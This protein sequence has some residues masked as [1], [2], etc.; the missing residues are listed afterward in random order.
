MQQKKENNLF[1]QLDFVSIVKDVCREWWVILLL[2]IAVSLLTNVFVNYTY[3]PQY[4]ASTTFVVTAKG[5]NANIYQ[6]LTSAKELAV[7]FSNVLESNVMKKKIAQ[8]LGMEN[9]NA[10]S[11]VEIL[12]ETNLIELKVTANSSLDAYRVMK[13]IMENYPEVSDYVISNVVLEV[14]KKPTIPTSPSNPLNA[15]GAMKKAFVISAAV[16]VVGFA[17]LSYLKDTV[18]NK[19]EV[20]EKVDAPLLGTVSHE[21]KAKSFAE[22]KKA[23]SLSM[24]IDNPMLSFRFVE[25]NKMMA[26]R[27]RSQLDKHGHKVLMLTSVIENEGKSTV[28]ANIALSLVQENKKVLLI[29]CDFRKPAQYKIFEAK[30]EDVVDFPKF[31][32]ENIKDTSLI[33]QYGDTSLYTIFNKKGSTNMERIYE[34]GALHKLVEIAREKMDYIILDTSPMALVSDTEELAQLADACILVIRQDMVLAKDINDAIDAL[35]K[36]NGNMLGCIFN[37]EVMGVVESVGHYG[38]GYGRYGYG[39]GKY[40]YGKRYG[41]GYGKTK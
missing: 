23:K 36:A 6:N 9:L 24:L 1:E 12:P 37:D 41:Y 17:V 22:V 5:M 15:T 32:S 10:T 14:I 26:S 40:G 19:R 2:S 21:R 39:Y 34:T 38:Y 16:L 3:Q 13:S 11:T 18:K 29:D 4:T 35:E 25:S 33:K 20:A 27:V 30:E 28:A 31:L 7:S 8:D